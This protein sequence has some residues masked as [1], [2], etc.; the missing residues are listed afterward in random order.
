MSSKYK[1][2]ML[3][4]RSLLRL[5]VGSPLHRLL[6]LP[7]PRRALH[8]Q[9]PDRLSVLANQP[10]EEEPFDHFA[11]PLRPLLSGEEGGAGGWW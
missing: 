1:S 9:P 3:S 6:R 10:P 5:I 7:E 4:F 8:Q 2:K 11:Q